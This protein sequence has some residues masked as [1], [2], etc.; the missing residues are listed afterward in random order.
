MT[1]HQLSVFIENTKG[2]LIEV[3]DLLKSKNVQLMAVSIA[4]T[5]EYGICR[6]ICCDPLAA[7]DILKKAGIA[8]A[9]SDVTAIALDNVPGAAADALRIYA[10]EGLSIAYLYSFVLGG[11]GILIFRTDNADR[12]STIA[13]SRGITTLCDDDLGRM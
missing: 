9:I 13:E 3:L 2:T 11:K 12:A 6:I 5:T 4:E 8:A 10:E 7:Y 1:V